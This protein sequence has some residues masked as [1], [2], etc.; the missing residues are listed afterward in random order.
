[1]KKSMERVVIALLMAAFILFISV[2]FIGTVMVT[3]TNGAE[4]CGQQIYENVQ[5]QIRDEAMI[6]G[7]LICR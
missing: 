1:M 5:E 4:P 2:V 7:G 3:T 6:Q